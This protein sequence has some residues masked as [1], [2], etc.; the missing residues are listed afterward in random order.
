[1]RFGVVPYRDSNSGRTRTLFFDALAVIERNRECEITLEN[2][3]SEI[4]ASPF[5][6][7]RVFEEMGTSFHGCLSAVRARQ[8]RKP[9]R[10]GHRAR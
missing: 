1:M 7:E 10:D 8:A 6:L 4:G 5:R 9:S 3:A 2:V